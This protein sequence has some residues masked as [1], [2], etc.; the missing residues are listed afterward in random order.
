MLGKSKYTP[1]I[2]FE[3]GKTEIR[4]CSLS[5]MRHAYM[6]RIDFISLKILSEIMI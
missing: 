5:L 6:S 2:G 3:S 4:F 1:K